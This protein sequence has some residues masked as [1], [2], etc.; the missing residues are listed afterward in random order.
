M[1]K[2]LVRS[3]LRWLLAGCLLSAVA[4]AQP[5]T[6]RSDC[7]QTA[8][9]LYS[10]IGSVGLDERRVYRVREATIDR[11]N[12]HLD[13][14]DGTLAFTED[15]CGRITGAYFEGEGEIRLRP[16]NRVER[17]SMALFT[18]M[19]ILDEQFSS[20]Y[21]RFNDDTAAVLQPFLSPAEDGGDFVKQRNQMSRNL[22]ASDALRL[23]L[24][25]SHF[26]PTPSGTEPMR[27]FPRLLHAHLLG[28]K[29]GAFE[30]F[31]DGANGEPVWA[32]QPRAKDEVLF[33]DTWTSFAPSAAA[34]EASPARSGIDVSIANFRIRAVVQP[35]RRLQASADIEVRVRSGG[36]RTLVFELSRYLKIDRVDEEG[37]PVEFLQNEP[38]E[39]TQLQRKGN[40]LVA[41]VF[42]APLAP[43]QRLKLHFS[44]AGDVLSE[45]GGGLLYVGE[46]GTW[47]PN[48][49]L[50]PAQFDLEFRY[51]AAWTLIATGKKIS[52]A[53]YE[54]Q[55]EE[56]AGEKVSHWVAERPIAVAGFNLGRYVRAEAKAGAVVVEAYGTKGVE[57]S[58]PRAPAEMIEAPTF[59]GS[60][61]PR[62]RVQEPIVVLRPPPSPA[63]NVQVVA[64][65]AAKA[66]ESFS[67]WFGPYPYGSLALTQMP[68]DVSQG[69]PGLVFLSSFAFLSPQEQTDLK[70]DP[71]ARLLDNQVLVHETAHQWWGDLVLWKSYRDQWFV[72]GLANYSALLVLEQN[73]PAQF[74]QV[75]EKCRSDLLSKNKDG[76]LL[77]TAG[78]VTL[79]QR[80]ISSHFPRGYDA[81]S[82]ER[83]TWL[84][85]ML[86]S[87]LRDSQSA[88]LSRNRKTNPEEPFFR[89]LR[90]VSERYAGKSI[91]TKELMQVFE[92]ELPRPLWY[93]NHHTLDWFVEGWINGTAVPRLE[94]REVRITQKERGAV[95]SGVIVQT[96]AP[97]DLV[98]AVPVYAM[99]SGNSLVFLGEVLADGT[100]TSFRLNAPSDARKIVLD[101]KQT[102]LTKLK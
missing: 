39:G 59:P 53:G 51:P 27:E 41:L 12:F 46:R 80:L 88:T 63:R 60:G 14:D 70:L 85:H 34:G 76:E 55:T 101:P 73:N 23:L 17:E 31:W 30:V 22:A 61:L 33:F 18:G 43:G 7:P 74:R 15:I 52:G 38:I 47:Y 62:T 98:T 5:S 97:E 25:F 40:D 93:E 65:R 32:G 29:L 9:A 16:P 1:T 26:L 6:S 79:G 81:I 28:G 67:A 78:P 56:T 19:A 92:E 64:D 4:H 24:D 45:A 36:E 66:I 10:R 87:M 58:F 57:R 77:R 102:I 11:P 8:A 35:P 95:V 90:K 86:R 13:F 21:L 69:W 94:T 50:S 20:A 44:Y 37:K 2:V 72:E 82:Y 49:G 83:G 71:V 99:T 42:P 91:S 96:D 54:D 84:F 100:E 68:G 3:R 75:L 89:A 48:F